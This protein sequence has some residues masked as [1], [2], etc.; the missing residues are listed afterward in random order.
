MANLIQMMKSQ[1]AKSGSSKKEILYFAKDSV[2]RVRFLQEL[3]HGYEFE[4]HNDWDTK[5]FELCKDPEDHENCKLCNDGI[6]IQ[7]NFIW[8]V[9]DYDSHSVKLIQFKATGVSPIP[10]LIEMYEEYGTIMD[11]DYKIKKVGQGQGSS[12]SVTPLDKERFSNSKAKPL[13]RMQVKEILEKAWTSNKVDDV[14]E[15]D[16]EEDEI[17]EVKPTK[18]KK[19]AKKEPTIHEKLEDL[20]LSDVKSIARLLGMNRKEL[21]NFDDIDELIE[22]LTDNFEDE[23]I[24]DCYDEYMDESEDD[25]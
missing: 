7:Q 11:R 1:I 4:F 14:D 3:D 5:I 8:C 16:E 24:Q 9:W 10:A 18:K 23:D 17:E 12:F 19:K 20:E 15:D 21:K 22:E 13:N 25:E 6:A 2:H